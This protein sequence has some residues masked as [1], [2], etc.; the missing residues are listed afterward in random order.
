[1]KT[2]NI[3]LG[4]FADSYEEADLY[5]KCALMEFAKEVGMS[6]GSTVASCEGETK[7]VAGRCYNVDAKMQIDGNINVN[8]VI[9][10]AQ[11][12]WND[13]YYISSSSI[14]VV[15]EQKSEP[16]QKPR[17]YEAVTCASCGQV[18][19]KGYEHVINKGSDNEYCL[20]VRCW[21]GDDDVFTCEC[22]EEDIDR[23]ALVMNPV[24]GE[25]DL[26]PVCGCKV[27]D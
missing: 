9:H 15:E 18:M 26:C 3:T 11:Q 4:I 16:V 23:E 25:R 19:V 12:R 14:F 5:G 21:D 27:I 1:M 20:C 2:L 6:S 7:Y 10:D 22:C 13:K 8:E 24:T 17:D